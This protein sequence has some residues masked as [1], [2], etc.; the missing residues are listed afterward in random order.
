MNPGRPARPPPAATFPAPELGAAPS[1][2]IQAT[3]RPPTTTAWPGTGAAPVPSTTVTLR[4]R[5]LEVVMRAF[6]SGVREAPEQR[7]VDVAA[8]DDRDDA[9]A[10]RQLQHAGHE[11]GQ[12]G[13]GRGLHQE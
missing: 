9:R 3:R 5:K 10:G 11:C 1:G 13:G 6:R 12:R 4:S 8:A 2:P 7:Q